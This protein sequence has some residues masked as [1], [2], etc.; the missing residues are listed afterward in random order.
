MPIDDIVRLIIANVE[1]D[2]GPEES[3]EFPAVWLE[4]MKK[5]A[6]LKPSAVLRQEMTHSPPGSRR[7]RAAEEI[8]RELE[9][10]DATA[11]ADKIKNGKGLIWGGDINE[12]PVPQGETVKPIDWDSPEI[13]DPRHR[14]HRTV[15]IPHTLLTRARHRL[16]GL[17]PGRR[18][19]LAPR[20]VSCS[21]VDQTLL[22]CGMHD[23]ARYHAANSR[24]PQ[25]MG[26]TAGH[27]PG[28]KGQG[29]PRRIDRLYPDPW[30]ATAVTDVRVIDMSGLSDHHAVMV[31]LSA[32]GMAH[33]LRRQVT[34]P[35]EL[36]RYRLLSRYPRRR[37]RRGRQQ[38]RRRS[39]GS[40]RCSTGPH[41]GGTPRRSPPGTGHR[42]PTTATRIH[43][44]K[45]HV[46]TRS[47][48]RNTQQAAA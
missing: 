42:P 5:L 1:R 14:V 7:L 35:P 48:Q 31:D 34:P 27:A 29:G 2:G 36:L 39:H 28:A 26:P 8:L 13:T 21:Y 3:G 12:G 45:N 10:G 16:R 32:R 11:Y 17:L 41:P 47:P 38:Q 33:A 40:H 46:Q 19:H 25:C 20:R 6:D 4:A 37:G 30:L 18:S 22:E 23:A 15:E 43:D 9:V 44:R 24:N